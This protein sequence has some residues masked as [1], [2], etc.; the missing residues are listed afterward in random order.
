MQ[1]VARLVEDWNNIK[2]YFNYF[3]RDG[4]V[5]A[6]VL[7]SRESRFENH[8]IASR[9]GYPEFLHYLDESA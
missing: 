7:Y 5:T 2:W 8:A 3:N 4:A 1:T 6:S 9:I